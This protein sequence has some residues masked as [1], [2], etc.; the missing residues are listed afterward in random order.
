MAIDTI[1]DGGADARVA[2]ARARNGCSTKERKQDAARIGG[3][4]K[5]ARDAAG[6]T[7]AQMARLIGVDRSAVAQWEGGYNFPLVPHLL[8][9]SEVLQASLADLLI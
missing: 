1:R 8:D 5:S 3:N 6:V 7:Q 9:I 4:I 2:R